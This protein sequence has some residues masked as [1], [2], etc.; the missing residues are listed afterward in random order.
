[1]RS[2]GAGKLAELRYYTFD[3]SHTAEKRCRIPYQCCSSNN[4]IY[5]KCKF[6]VISIQIKHFNIYFVTFFLNLNRK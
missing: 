6:K 3:L 5:I 4:T 1:M 2:M